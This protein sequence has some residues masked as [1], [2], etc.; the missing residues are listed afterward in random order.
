MSASLLVAS[1][2][3]AVAAALH[4]LL[5]ESAILRGAT[6]TSLPR[7]RLPSTFAFLGMLSNAPDAALQWSY[8]RAAWHFLTIDFVFASIVFAVAASSASPALVLLVRITAVRYATYA[9]A[10][11]IIVALKHRSIWRAPQWALLL[12]IA[13]CAW[14]S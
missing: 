9:V 11:F 6:K 3:S 10:W 5:G 8:L 12:A 13:A 7:L 4:G 1:L 14:P 2:L